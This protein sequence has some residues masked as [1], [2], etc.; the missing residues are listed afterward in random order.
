MR[1]Q[2]LG[3][4]L[5]LRS[6]DLAKENGCEFSYLMATGIYSQPMFRKLG[7]NVLNEVSYENMLDPRGKKIVWDHREHKSVQLIFFMH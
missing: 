7:Y 6:H 3:Q 5:V 4:E 1:G 2:G